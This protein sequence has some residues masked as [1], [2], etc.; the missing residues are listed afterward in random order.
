MKVRS[1]QELQ[2]K[3][4]A[5]ISWRKKELVDYKFVIEKNKKSTAVTPLIRGGISLCYAHWEG[6]VK[7]SSL[8][9]TSYISTLKVPLKDIKINFVA[10]N[11]K[12]KFNKINNIEESISLINEIQDLSDKIC[13][14][15]DKEIIETKSNL[16]YETLKEI[17]LSLGFD[18]SFF[19]LNENFIDKKLV[20]VRNE[21]AH[22][23]Y[24]DVK[25]EDFN[26]VFIKLIPL[27]DNYKTLI[28]NNA[29]TK[30][31]KK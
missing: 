24:R 27:L 19:S 29:S 4:D 3:L 10:L 20:D 14:I 6:F 31:Y 17:I 15:Y 30:E 7:M 21:I 25:I 5:E 26:E 11:F 12:K 16:R 22:G 8:L 9:Y 23:V 28:E 18:L 13:K 1:L 2:D